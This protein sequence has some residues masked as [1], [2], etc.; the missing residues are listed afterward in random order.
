MCVLIYCEKILQIGIDHL[1]RR[2]E[3]DFRAALEGDHG[4]TGLCEC[5]GDSQGRFG[6]DSNLDSRP[7]HS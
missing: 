5:R 2:G 1:Q 6:V 4:R 7:F 3:E